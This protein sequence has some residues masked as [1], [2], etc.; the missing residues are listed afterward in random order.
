MIRRAAVACLLVVAVAAHL[1]AQQSPII[2]VEELLFAAD[3]DLLVL[4][5]K[6]P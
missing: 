1:R 5:S 6:H 3:L 2:S 4:A